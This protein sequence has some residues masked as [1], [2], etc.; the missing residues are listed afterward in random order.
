MRKRMIAY[1]VVALMF[2]ISGCGL[3]DILRPETPDQEWTLAV[4]VYV[5]TS[6]TANQLHDDGRIDDDLYVT[7]NE[8]LDYAHRALVE[9]RSLLD[10]GL[11]P[12]FAKEQ[13]NNYI[14]SANDKLPTTVEE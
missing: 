3:T 9:W 11:D 2:M 10:D 12:E 7:V 6:D 13:F 8:V 14:D 5:Y 1:F 4:R